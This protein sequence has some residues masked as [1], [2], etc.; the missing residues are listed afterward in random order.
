MREAMRR[1]FAVTDTKAPALR[2]ASALSL[3][4]TYKNVICHDFPPEIGVM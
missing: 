4:F 1:R 2:F 3:R